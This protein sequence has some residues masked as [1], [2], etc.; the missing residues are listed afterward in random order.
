MPE[1]IA[2]KGGKQEGQ[3][4]QTLHDYAEEIGNLGTWTW[5]METN[6]AVYS[7]NMFRLF[8]ME[9]GEV[10]PSFDTIPKF[11]HPDDRQRLLAGAGQLKE[12][13]QP[14]LIGYRIIRKDNEVRYLTNKLKLVRNSNH[15]R[16][17]IGVT[18]DV[19]E[20]KLEEYASLSLKEQ[21][22]QQTNDKYQE[23]I[24]SIDEGFGVAEVI[25]DDKSN[26]VDMRWLLLNPQFERLTGLSRELLLSG[27][28]VREA[29][30]NI[31]DKWYDK[32]GDVVRRNQPMRFEEYSPTFDKWYDVYVFPTDAPELKHV[33]ILFQD[34]TERKRR[35]QQQEYLLKISDA[36]GSVSS[37][38]VIEEI[39]TN[40]AMNHFKA[41]R[42]YYCEVDGD[43]AIIRRDAARAGLSP[44]VGTYPLN[45]FVTFKN[46]VDEGQPF[47]VD[48][49]Y[50]SGMVDEHLRTL[51]IPF[52][53]ISFIA[54]PVVKSGT[55]VGI[56]CLVQSTPRDWMQSEIALAVETAQRTWA[57]VENANAERALRQNEQKYRTLF[58][59][60]DEGYCII[61]MIYDDDGKAV[62]WLYLQVNRAFE[63][64]NGLHD[65]EGKTIVEMAPDIEGKWMEIYDKVAKTGEPLRFE[66]S[67]DALNRIFSLYAFRIGEEHERKVAVIF[68]DIT[69]RKKTDEALRE[70]EKQLRMLLRQRDEFIGVASHE[71]KTPVTVMKAYAEI[72]QERLEKL[73]G[74][75][76]GKLLARLNKQ[77]DRLTALI[78]DLLDTTKISEGQLPLNPE[79][80]DLNELLQERIEEIR[81]MASHKFNLK[82]RSLPGI[83]ADRERIGQVI[84]NLLSNAIKYSPADA[85][86]TIISEA[87]CNTVT[88]SICDEGYG[89]P[90]EALD[91]IF[92]RFF[93][94]SNNAMDTFPGMG[95]GLYI[96]AQ[97]I[98]KHNGSISV[99]SKQGEGSVFT[100]T[101][102]INTDL[103]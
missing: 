8:G 97:I 7:D 76:D 18:Q 45:S 5:N 82:K 54:V 95:L 56:L 21:T 77:I 94:V 11:V 63:L 64:N 24:S 39:V 48:N 68:T 73:G 60:I 87:N 27:K 71:L 50:T 49:V 93:R 85:T 80:I 31:E 23:L 51:C 15:E 25:L 69:E 84:T 86:V 4:L 14:I 19:T 58:D 78:N 70:N 44:V 43:S 81:R 29:A 89:I 102:P 32:Y 35:E 16:V 30:P 90:E 101:L 22:V 83:N 12:N 36:L 33:G 103:T 96:T 38:V 72:V 59:S 9:P 65:A 92:E 10:E 47:I 20:A 28:T 67:S 17:I 34:I 37:P 99:S 41:D 55:V 6:K 40:T 13:Q 53:I 57:A 42:C 52:Q 79:P 61:Q 2:A 100:F 46:V 88:V 75:E 98:Q 62:D 74:T 1:N 66:E 91:R 26:G 3:L